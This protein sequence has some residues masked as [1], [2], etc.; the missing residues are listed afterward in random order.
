MREILFAVRLIYLTYLSCAI[1]CLCVRMGRA[2]KL[3]KLWGKRTS[4]ES[5]E[6]AL[7]SYCATIAGVSEKIRG[8]CSH[9]AR[10]SSHIIILNTFSAYKH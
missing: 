7:P 3:L 9:Y 6:L 8:K 10:I 5:E 4:D 2:E 1:G